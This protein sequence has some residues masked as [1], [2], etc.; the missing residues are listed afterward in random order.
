MQDRNMTIRGVNDTAYVIP[1]HSNGIFNI[2]VWSFGSL[3]G[4]FL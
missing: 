2:N 1:V 4:D 3:P